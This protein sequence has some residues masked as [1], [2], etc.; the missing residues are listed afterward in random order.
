MSWNQL[1]YFYNNEY[2]LFQH[3]I[4]QIATDLIKKVQEEVWKDIFYYH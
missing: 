1:Y 3:E 4:Y 2:N